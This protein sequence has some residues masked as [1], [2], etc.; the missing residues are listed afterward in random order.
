M[1]FSL[2]LGQRGWIITN[3]VGKRIM[4]NMNKG[5]CFCGAVEFE[6]SGTPAVMGY[7]HCDDCSSWAAAP[8]NAFGLWPRDSIKVTK[9]DVSGKPPGLGVNALVV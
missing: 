6:V 3:R 8:I 5:Q 4:G 2:A 9:G 7:C 1:R